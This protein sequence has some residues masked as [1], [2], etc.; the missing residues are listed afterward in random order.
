MSRVA[1]FRAFP[2]SDR[3]ALVQAAALLVLSRA[4]LVTRRVSVRRVAATVDRV[5]SWLPVPSTEAPTV[6]RLVWAVDV[7]SRTV[8]VETT[9]LPRALTGS[10]LLARYG[11]AST[12]RI[13]V[14]REGGEFAAHA[15]V[16]RDG[17]VVLGDLPDLEMFVPLPLD[18]LPGAWSDDRGANRSR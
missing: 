7:A 4:L 6:D 5:C 2:P 17:R 11:Y 18:E 14:R 15:W 16:E 12:L 13:G 8:P 10:A 3:V 1:R 9:C